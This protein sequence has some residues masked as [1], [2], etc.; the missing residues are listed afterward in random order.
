M[1][2]ANVG[3]MICSLSEGGSDGWVR[4][5][6]QRMDDYK[7]CWR[8]RLKMGCIRGCDEECIDVREMIY[9]L[10]DGWVGG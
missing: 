8:V 9:S 4:G 2:E 3:E 7:S 5:V 6:G 1:S 10:L